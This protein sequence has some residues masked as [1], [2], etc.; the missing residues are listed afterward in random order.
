[1]NS[2]KITLSF[3]K[4][5]VL[6]LLLGIA[7]LPGNAQE[8]VPTVPADKTKSSPISLG[9]GSG[10][11]YNYNSF[12]YDG[13]YPD[14][15]NIKPTYNIG[16]FFG[17]RLSPRSRFRVELKYSTMAYGVHY[18]A[19]GNESSDTPKKFVLW[20]Y[21][22]GFSFR[23]DY[24]FLTI[25]KLDVLFAP[26]L[27]FEYNI[28]DREKTTYMNGDKSNSSLINRDYEHSLSGATAGLIFRYNLNDHWGI[29]MTPEYTYFFKKLYSDNNG[30]LQRLAVDLGFEFKF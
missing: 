19:A 15:Y 11:D 2:K 14:K 23:Y 6:I 24:R 18:D 7:Q 16:A 30:D 3:L 10:I 27:K 4:K 22:F 17:L 21:N 29:T 28:T 26:A 5:M 12:N 20:Q 9:L 1:M 25:N 13:D 8:P